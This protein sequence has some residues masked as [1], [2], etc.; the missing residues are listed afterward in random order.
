MSKNIPR[1]TKLKKVNRE[2]FKYYAGFSEYFVED[3]IDLLNLEKSSLIMDP[4]NG[5]GTTTYIASKKGLA[6]IGVDINPI[7]SIVAK[8]R[9]FSCKR[10]EFEVEDILTLS[11]KYRKKVNEDDSLNNWFKNDTVRI[12]RNIER[13]IFKGQH[14]RDVLFLKME[15]SNLQAFLCLALF[16]SVKFLAKNYKSSNPTWTKMPL[17]SERENYSRK[18]IECVFIKECEYLITNAIKDI[19]FNYMPQ[20]LIGDS[21]DLPIDSLKVDT[22]I[23][24]P[25]YCTRIDY[26]MMTILELAILN[27]TELELNNLRRSLIGAPVIQKAQP[28]LKKEWGKTCLDTLEKIRDH[29]SRASSTYYY[30]TYVQY[31]S[32]M[33]FSFMELDRVLKLDGLCVLVIQDSFYKDIFVDL[34]TIMLEMA[35]NLGWYLID[36]FEFLG[37]NNI[38]GIN[39]KSKKYRTNSNTKES[40]LILKKAGVYLD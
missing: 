6:S 10:D 40:V 20:I 29:Y 18:E 2:H 4:W 21:Q 12:I 34:R 39:T 23:T 11:R 17:Y 1:T 26:A 25:P 3:I 19:K 35:E 13:A 7:M 38:V 28:I 15:Y 33:Y 24:S 30:K 14:L 16:N 36:E 5:S 22:I 9:M 27:M 32:S 31:F 37:S 8:A